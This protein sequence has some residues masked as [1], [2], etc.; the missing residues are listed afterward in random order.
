MRL[1]AG[2]LPTPQA[3][4]KRGKSAPRDRCFRNG[5]LT[6]S[7]LWGRATVNRVLPK[8][9][10]VWELISI[11]DSLDVGTSTKTMTISENEIR[12]LLQNQKDPKGAPLEDEEQVFKR[13]SQ[14]SHN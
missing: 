13:I 7:R 3:L 2:D 1:L 4:R 8:E 14:A 9:K 12:I 5:N 6:Q 11:H 10:G